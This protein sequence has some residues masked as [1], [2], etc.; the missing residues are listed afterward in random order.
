MDVLEIIQ[1]SF[2][3]NKRKSCEEKIYIFIANN[4]KSHGLEEEFNDLAQASNEDEYVYIIK[5][6]IVT[7]LENAVN[8][9]RIQNDRLN[10]VTSLL[11]QYRDYLKIKDKTQTL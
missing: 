5:S 4:I 7:I 10:R 2:K 11:F 9:N 3:S 8:L 1:S 6:V